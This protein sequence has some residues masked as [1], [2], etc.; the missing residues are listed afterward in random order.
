MPSLGDVFCVQESFRAEKSLTRRHLSEYTHIEAELG[1]INFDDLL[2]HLEE[3][4]CR[5]VDYALADPSIKELIQE[6][7]PGFKPP[8]RPFRRMDYK[9]AI[10]WLN[11]RGVPN[12]GGEPH[13]FGDDIAEAAERRMVDEIN[14]PI[15]LIKF[16]AE[17]K[18]F[19]MKKDLEDPRATESVDCL[20]PNVG[21]I[22]GG[23][24]RIDDSAELLEAYKKVGIGSDPYYW[25]TDQR[26]YVSLYSEFGRKCLLSDRYGT[27]SHGGYGLG[28][29]RFLAWMCDQYTVRSCS[30]YPRWTGRCTPSVSHPFLRRRMMHFCIC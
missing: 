28:L 18:S 11:D 8:T 21:E 25:Y 15:F 20:M 22:V 5:S 4:M 23:S 7:N 2:S 27:C 6:L 24:M 30:L 26:K 16:P 29:E 3:F 14:V 19:Y 17:I 12:E 13:K 1:F 9:E 10:Q